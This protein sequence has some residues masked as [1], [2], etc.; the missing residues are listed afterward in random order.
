MAGPGA[1]DEAVKGAA[2]F[3]QTA[4]PVMVSYDPNEGIPLVVEG[5]LNAMKAAAATDSVKRFVLISSSTAA[6]SP[7]PNVEFSADEST[8]N[9]EAIKAAW[10]PPPY[11]GE[12][13][14]LDVYS[15]SKTKENKLRGCS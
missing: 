4:T 7:T 14:K 3:I 9:D 1:F 8:W 12:Q 5:T 2:G 6:I 11:E 10:A 15:A 13:L